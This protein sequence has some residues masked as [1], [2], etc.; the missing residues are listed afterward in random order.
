MPARCGGPGSPALHPWVWG[1]FCGWRGAT[2]TSWG[3]GVGPR[4]WDSRRGQL[5]WS[6]AKSK[7]RPKEG[8][9]PGT[10]HCRR[11]SSLTKLRRL[12]QPPVLAGHGAPA[13]PRTARGEQ[14][15]RWDSARLN[16][17]VF[18]RTHVMHNQQQQLQG[19][20]QTLRSPRCRRDHH[21]VQ[22]RTALTDFL[23]C[24]PCTSS[25]ASATY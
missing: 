10:A 3:F 1:R 16:R 15:N 25:L 13:P 5:L 19:K 22:A 24:T 6:P 9:V 23:L 7:P 2:Q 18:K 11:K 21:L 17:F 8:V 4:R 14:S 12:R 20:S